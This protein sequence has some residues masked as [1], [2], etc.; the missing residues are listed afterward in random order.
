M[1]IHISSGASK[2][3]INVL[4]VIGIQTILE[5]LLIFAILIALITEWLTNGGFDPN[6]TQCITVH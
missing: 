6:I 4:E 2:T 5:V 1:P 3:V